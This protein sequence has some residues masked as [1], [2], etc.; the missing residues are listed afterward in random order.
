MAKPNLKLFP[1]RQVIRAK[2]W[3]RSKNGQALMAAKGNKAAEKL[4]QPPRHIADNLM[5]G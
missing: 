1:E 3:L 2:R 4:F 5:R